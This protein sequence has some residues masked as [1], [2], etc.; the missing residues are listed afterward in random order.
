MRRQD[1]KFYIAL[2][3]FVDLLN[4][5]TFSK[6]SIGIC[7]YNSN[8]KKYVVMPTI[9]ELFQH[10]IKFLPVSKDRGRLHVLYK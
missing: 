6:I 7:A 3:H 2:S 1:F 8:H 9:T 4:S 10:L 5:K